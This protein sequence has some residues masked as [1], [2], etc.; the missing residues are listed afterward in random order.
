MHSISDREI[1]NTK[2]AAVYA[3]EE[4]PTTAI[5]RDMMGNGRVMV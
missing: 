3:S 5:M 1:V 4:R 2:T